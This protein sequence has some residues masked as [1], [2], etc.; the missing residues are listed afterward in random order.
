MNFDA[1]IIE[2]GLKLTEISNKM[3]RSATTFGIEQMGPPKTGFWSAI[4]QFLT[5]FNKIGIKMLRKQA[6]IK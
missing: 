2:I 5:D 1:K 6:S 3:T 4:P